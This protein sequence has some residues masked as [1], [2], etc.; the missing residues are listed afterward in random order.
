MPS[1]LEPAVGIPGRRT[2]GGDSNRRGV[3]AAGLV[4]IL[5][6]GAAAAL[7]DGFP[8]VA[9]RD[10]DRRPVSLPADLI[11]RIFPILVLLTF[12][13]MIASLILAGRSLVLRERRSWTS[14]ALSLFVVVGMVGG[15]YLLVRLF[16][17][18]RGGGEPTPAPSGAPTSS[19]PPGVVEPGGSPL[20]AVVVVGVA[21]TVL[22]GALAVMF[23]MARRGGGAG[24]PPAAP[25]LEEVE[26]GI[27]ELSSIPDP[28]RAVIACYVRM[29]RAIDAAGIGRAPSDTPLEVLAKVLGERLPAAPATQRLTGLFERA[30]FSQH[31][32]DEA[33][34]REALAALEDVRPN[35]RRAP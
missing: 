22:L 14:R 3:A 18:L 9:G 32:V 28:R 13:A 4:A 2:A 6:I 35:L 34:R 15:V 24:V 23:V 12:L 25:A 21:L 27:Q 11:D 20:V 29:Q 26:A 7:P 10:V 8:L 16:P 30:K 19:I 5:L 1:E 17:G 31:A 33:M